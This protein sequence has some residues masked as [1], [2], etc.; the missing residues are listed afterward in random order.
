[1]G[2]VH[3]TVIFSWLSVAARPRI[4]PIK[5][6]WLGSCNA[7]SVRGRKLESK[8]FFNVHGVDICFLKATHLGMG[9]ALSFTNYF[10]Q[11][12]DRPTPGGCTAN[13]AARS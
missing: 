8:L 5:A 2:T 4:F 9:K 13:L 11:R 3:K 12:I 7:D 1:M 10:L 6:L